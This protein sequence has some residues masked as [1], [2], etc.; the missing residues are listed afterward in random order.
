MYIQCISNRSSSKPATPT[1]TRHLDH[2][3]RFCRR[4]GEIPVFR[5][6]HCFSSTASFPQPTLSSPQSP[7]L[8]IPQS[9]TC[10]ILVL[11]GSYNRNRVKESPG[12]RPGLFSLTHLPITLLE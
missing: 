7:H 4:S 3:R 12:P 1:K 2:R 6:C 5:L 11:S 8:L 9:D 10:G